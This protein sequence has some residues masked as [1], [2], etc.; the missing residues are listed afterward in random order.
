M[1][2][3]GE[4]RASECW[5]R[6]NT[7]P[8]EI[9]PPQGNVTAFQ[10]P[11]NVFRHFVL[12]DALRTGS[13]TPFQLWRAVLVLGLLVAALAP[14]PNWLSRDPKVARLPAPSAAT[15][16]ACGE[17]WTGWAGGL[18]QWGSPQDN[19]IFGQIPG[20]D[21]PPVSFTAVIMCL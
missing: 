19:G 8:G 9:M 21:D 14:W 16:E 5:K 18:G 4:R 11:L 15:R 13:A 6:G 3:G 10:L 2:P 1:L 20:P 17:S 7:A 12:A